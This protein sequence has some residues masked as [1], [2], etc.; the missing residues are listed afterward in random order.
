MW[1]KERTVLILVQH[2]G[3]RIASLQVLVGKCGSRRGLYWYWYSIRGTGSLP[4]K[5]WY[6]NTHQG[7]DCIDTGT[8]SGSGAETPFPPSFG[9]EMWIKERTVQHQWQMWEEAECLWA[10]LCAKKKHQSS[11]DNLNR[12]KKVPN[13]KESR[14]FTT[15]EQNSTEQTHMERKILQ[16]CTLVLFIETEQWWLCFSF[17][18]FHKT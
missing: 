17:T 1:I 2:Q 15:T 16:T 8:A 3:H 7:E 5:F 6:E 18:S 9:W 11:H 13:I 14:I 10:S 4:S 12:N